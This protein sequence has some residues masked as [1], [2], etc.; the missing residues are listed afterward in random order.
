VAELVFTFGLAFLIEE[1]VQLFWGKTSVD[2]VFALIGVTLPAGS[3]VARLTI[4]QTG[5]GAALP[6][7]GG[8]PDLPPARPDGGHERIE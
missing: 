1:A 3:Q 7:D 6:A 4:T 5:A 2:Y 8:D